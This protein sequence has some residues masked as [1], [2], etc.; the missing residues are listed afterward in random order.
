LPYEPPADDLR[1]RSRDNV[2]LTLHT[3]FYSEQSILDLEVEASRQV[4]LVLG[5]KQSEYVVDL[6]Q[7]D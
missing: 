1:L 5:G 2:I 4:A 7:L 6:D 3:A